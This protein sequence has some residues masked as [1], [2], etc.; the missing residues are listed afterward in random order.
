MSKWYN[1]TVPVSHALDVLG[2]EPGSMLVRRHDRWH[3]MTPPIGHNGWVIGVNNYHLP[4]WV[5]PATVLS[6]T[7]NFYV[8]PY[9]PQSIDQARIYQVSQA[10]DFLAPDAGSMLMRIN[11]NWINLQFPVEPDGK[12]LA[13]TSA[14]VVAWVEASVLPWWPY[15]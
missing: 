8:P 10:L 11:N 12:I 14:G 4:E 3:T 2:T 9:P 13:S 1:A 6:Q 15:T 5:E 7:P